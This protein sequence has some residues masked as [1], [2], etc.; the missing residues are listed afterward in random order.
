MAE[1]TVS[2][3]DEKITPKIYIQLANQ[4]EQDIDKAIK[5][6]EN[7]SQSNISC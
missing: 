3:N 1:T 4:E 2:P 7:L 5:F 6:L